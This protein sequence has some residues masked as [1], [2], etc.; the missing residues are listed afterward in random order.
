MLLDSNI[1]LVL[2]CCFT[3]QAT[4][5]VMLGRSVHLITLSSWANMN[6]QFASTSC[7]YFHSFRNWQQPFLNEPVKGRRMTIEIISWSISTKVW[8]QAGIKLATPGSAIR[9]PS[10]VRHITDCAMRSRTVILKCRC[11]TKSFLFGKSI[12]WL[13]QH[14][15]AKIRMPYYFTRI[16]NKAN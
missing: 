2:V 11:A 4:A 3:T 10:V 14:L 7:T 8:D 13:Y 5:M 15:W 16:S 9:Y 12:P 6:K 1:V